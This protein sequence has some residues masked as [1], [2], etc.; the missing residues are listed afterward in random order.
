MD[1]IIPVI[2]GLLAGYFS[3]QFGI[4][5]GF[6]MQPALR[7]V[8]GAPALVSLG[9]PIPVF[10][11]SAITGAYNYYRSGFVDLKL[12]FYLS[13]FGV[14]A[15]IA[16]SYAT[17]LVI[18]DLLLLVTAI[19]LMATSFRY[20][21][22]GKRA[23]GKRAPGESKNGVSLKKGVATTASITGA[24][25]GFFS[26]FLGLGGGFLLVPA[27]TIIF[28]KD[29][30]TAIGTSL[31]VIIAYAI[32]GGITHFQLGHVD[33]QLAVLMAVGIVP[34]AYIGSKVAIGLPE[35]LLRRLFGIF[36]FTVAAYFAVFE[37]MVLLGR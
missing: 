30:K 34:G 32:P 35:A 2:I 22:A 18:G 19:V 14:I 4:G 33:S 31:V 15:T 8:I 29:I 5:G 37:I 24:F 3:G 12:A 16:G 1:Y 28:N 17:T 6:L 36:L 27:L 7:L 20:I 21:L 11:V 10:I 9:T 23:P 25:V 26:G 13:L